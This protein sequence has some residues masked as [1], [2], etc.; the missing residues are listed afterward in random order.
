MHFPCPQLWAW[1]L[2]RLSR[3]LG[4]MGQTPGTTLGTVLQWLGTVPLQGQA[5]R[6]SRFQKTHLM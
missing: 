2:L 5:G 1:Q 6:G 4:T 3:A